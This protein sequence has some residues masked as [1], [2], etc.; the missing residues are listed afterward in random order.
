MKDI[1]NEKDVAKVD[2]MPEAPVKKSAKELKQEAIAKKY[3]KYENVATNRLM[4]DGEF[5]EEAAKDL[6]SALSEANLSAGSNP[7]AK[8]LRQA[9]TAIPNA[10]LYSKILGQLSPYEEFIGEGKGAEYILLNG[11]AVNTLDNTKFV[12][13]YR[14]D[15]GGYTYIDSIDLPDITSA[16]KVELSIATYLYVQYYISGKLDELVNLIKP[17]IDEA[18]TRR[19]AKKVLDLI[20]LIFRQTHAKDSSTAAA[21]TNR[22][23][24]TSTLTQV[25]AVKEWLDF[26]NGLAYDNVQFNYGYDTWDTATSTYVHHNFVEAYNSLP[27]EDRVYVC[28]YQTYNNLKKYALTF[29]AKADVDAYFKMDKWI[30]LPTSIYNNFVGG[31]NPTTKGTIDQLVTLSAYNSTTSA[32]ERVAGAVMV[33]DRRA[34][35]RVYNYAKTTSEYYAPNDTTELF[36]FKNWAIKFLKWGQVAVY[37]NAALESAFVIPTTTV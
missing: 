4:S 26:C 17:Q 35:K 2:A 24:G 6:N 19:Q 30:V 15:M 28:E 33:L 16:D 20:Q 12:P 34:L 7:S 37:E 29:L 13:Q 27:E 10:S 18:F 3:K 8:Y 5:G 14:N 31:T 36:G 23:V 21:L 1:Q 32:Y 11:L 9:F 22:L 25:D